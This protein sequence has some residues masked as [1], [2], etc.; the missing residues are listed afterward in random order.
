MKSGSLVTRFGAIALG[1]FLLMGA[2]WFLGFNRGSLPQGKV[3]APQ[4]AMFIPRQAPLVLSLLVNPGKLATYRKLLTGQSGANLGQPIQ[5]LLTKAGLDYD[6]DIQPWVGDEITLAIASLDLDRQPNNGQQ[7]GYLLALK[8]ND[9][10]RS[11][12]FLDG[13]WQRQATAGQA[14]KVEQYQGVKLTSTQGKQPNWQ[15][16]KKRPPASLDAVATAMVGKEFVLVAN[17][18]KVLRDALNNVQAIDLGLASASYY[19]QAVDSLEQPRIGFAF[20]NLPELAQWRLKST[21][22]PTITSPPVYDRLAVAIGANQDGLLLENALIT[23]SG[24]DLPP[25]TPTLTAPVIA[26]KYLPA[27]SALVAAGLDLQTTWTQLNQGIQGYPLLAN[28]LGQSLADTGDR[29]GLD[30]SQDVFAWVKGEYGLGLVPSAQGRQADWVFVAEESPSTQPGL[31][32]LDQIAAKQGF[33][34]GALK[35]G[36]QDISAWTKLITSVESAA[37]KPTGS[38]LIQ[39][40]VV[41]AHLNLDNYTVLAS[42]LDA[43]NQAVQPQSL[44]DQSEFKQAIAP[45]AQPNNGYL[46]LDWPKLQPVLE[47]KLPLLQTIE[48]LSSPLFDHL[49]SLSLASY[50]R[51]GRIQRSQI[52]VRLS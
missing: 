13:F 25:L 51:Q 20:V 12:A 15:P 39:A 6:K 33:S 44:L 50:G 8:V 30:L 24:V 23:A 17:S 9:V 11:R 29:W 22:K 2:I 46:Y 3:A 45:L 19:Q 27:T 43:I 41:G 21:A 42:T 5:T 34:A 18:A 7:P 31:R 48:G 36:T 35:V 26:L 4:A 40:E 47:Q 37:A 52:F 16:P 32:Q 10:E 28:L 1:V 38:T 14:L 49:R